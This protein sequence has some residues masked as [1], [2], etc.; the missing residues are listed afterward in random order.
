MILYLSFQYCN[1]NFQ[2]YKILYVKGIIYAYFIL[3]KKNVCIILA[4]SKLV[5]YIYNFFIKKT[6]IEEFFVIKLF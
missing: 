6:F 2:K 4:K 5:K 3:R 1:I